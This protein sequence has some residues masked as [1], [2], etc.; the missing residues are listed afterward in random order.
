MSESVEHLAQI[1]RS[2]IQLTTSCP[3]ADVRNGKIQLTV[4]RISI[5]KKMKHDAINDDENDDASDGNDNH[6]KIQELDGAFC[7][8]ISEILDMTLPKQC[9]S[10][11]AG[12]HNG[13]CPPE[14]PK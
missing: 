9:G 4:V 1:D 7:E 3:P 11:W 10:I 2:E 6:M 8:N 14:S 13:K 5:F 12:G